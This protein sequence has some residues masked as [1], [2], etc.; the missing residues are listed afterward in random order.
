MVSNF[1]FDREDIKPEFKLAIKEIAKLLQK[2]ESFKL[3]WL[4]IVII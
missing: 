3:M 4:A 2:S 1:D